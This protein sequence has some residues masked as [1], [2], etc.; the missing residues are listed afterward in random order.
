MGYFEAEP[1]LGH[2]LLAP[3][4][5]YVIGSK[6]PSGPNLAPV[7]NVTSVSRVP[8]VVVVA[9]YREWTTFQ[10]LQAAERFTISVPHRKLNDVVW[11]LGDRYSGFVPQEGMTKLDAC[12][13]HVSH[14]ASSAGPVLRDAIGWL[15]CRIVGRGDIESDHGIFFGAVTCA[16]FNSR[17]LDTD[18][19]YTTNSEPVMQ[20]VRNTF[21]TSTE[22]WENEY[23]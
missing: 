13:E 8:Q 5:A 6:G 12:E 20:V 3:R 18:G 7:S 19:G 14:E 15:E 23:F 1:A 21:T 11:R 4:V 22:Y 17:Y 16:H 2:R 10:N 9:V